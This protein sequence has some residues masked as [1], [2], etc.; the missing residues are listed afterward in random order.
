MKINTYHPTWG[1]IFSTTILSRAVTTKTHVLPVPDFACTI[2]SE[3]ILYLYHIY[4]YAILVHNYL[5]FK[6]FRTAQSTDH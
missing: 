5:L 3:N 4:M 6:N 1:V 2:K